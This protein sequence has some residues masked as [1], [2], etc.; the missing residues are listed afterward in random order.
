MPSSSSFIKDYIGILLFLIFEVI[1]FCFVIQVGYIP[2]ESMTPT[3][4]A[5]AVYVGLR[6]DHSYQRG[7]IVTFYSQEYKKDMIKRIVGVGG[8]TI[9]FSNGQVLV[10]GNVQDE[11]YLSDSISTASPQVSFTVPDGC[12][13][14]LGDNRTNSLDARYW[15]HPYISTQDIKS[16]FLLYIP[17]PTE[18]SNPVF[19]L[20]VF[21]IAIV[22]GILT[23]LVDRFR[24]SIH[25]T[26]TKENIK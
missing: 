21:G 19:Y 24:R 15:Q 13:F 16:A 5:K 1:L 10:N 6:L 18:K 12:V 17:I 25:P 9:T 8:D 4:P 7:E 26:A 11:P 14:L 22:I 2:S 20:I 23:L 3:I